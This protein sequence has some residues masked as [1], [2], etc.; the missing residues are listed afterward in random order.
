MEE[1]SDTEIVDAFANALDSALAQHEKARMTRW[2]VLIEVIDEGGSYGLW[3]VGGP[4]SK[5]WDMLGM[6]EY[7]KT[8]QKAEIYAPPLDCD[9]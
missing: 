9:D 5:P 2:I 4:D 7:A 8:V 1:R 6:L 3:T